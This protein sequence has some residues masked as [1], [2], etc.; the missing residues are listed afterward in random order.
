MFLNNLADYAELLFRNRKLNQIALLIAH[1]F[2][3]TRSRQNVNARALGCIH[4]YVYFVHLYI[5]VCEYKY[6]ILSER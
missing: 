2:H 4:T 1:F 6:N 5:C 3:M